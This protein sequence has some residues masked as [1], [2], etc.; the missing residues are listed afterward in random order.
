MTQL[1][2]PTH[3]LRMDT[4]ELEI[5]PDEKETIISF[6]AGRQLTVSSTY[7]VL[8]TP[9]DQKTSVI[10]S[11]GYKISAL[12]IE[13]AILGL[14]YIGEVM[15]VGL[16]DEEYGQRVTAAVTLEDQV[17]IPGPCTV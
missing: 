17:F 1:P 13:R 6:L 4:I 8:F 15:V 14:D 16:E 3:S 7:P 11:G 12:D 10:K 5:L 9:I 2:P